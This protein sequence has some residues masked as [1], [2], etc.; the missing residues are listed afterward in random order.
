M[1]MRKMAGMAVAAVLL[2]AGAAQADITIET[3]PV[4]NPGNAADTRTQSD[5]TSGYGAVAYEYN[6]GKYEVTAGQYTAFLNAVAATDIYSLY[7]TNMWSD[8][9]GCKIRRSG[10]SG[11]YTYS[12]AGDYA[13]RPVNFVSWGDSVRF[14][15]WLTNGQGSGSTETGA[16]NLN[17]AVT[18]PGLMSMVVPS[19]S[20]R[21]AWSTGAKPYFLLTSEDEWYKAAYHDKNAA[22][23][24]TYFVYPTG[25]NTAPT[26]T[27]VANQLSV[28]PGSA[29]YHYV[30]D[31]P[32][33]VGA[34]NSKP[35]T[36]A[37]GTF[38][39]GGNLA[40]WN[41]AVLG[42][43]RG[44]RGGA[45]GTFAYDLHAS[46]REAYYFPTGQDGSVGFRVSEV[47]EPASMAVL[48][49]GSIGMLLRR[50]R[51]MV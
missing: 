6:I 37:Y 31:S 1:Q 39:Q 16:Y 35:S 25:S 42:P 17:G 12:V 14:A 13:N 9:Y 50:R 44:L 5:G 38:D 36:S 47:P 11:S 34:Y 41:E 29:N 40:E 43:C 30:V 4:G 48:A 10:S 24:A 19:A 2:A 7:N 32:T 49:L 3:V 28:A 23:A 51:R 26:A 33:N 27:N 18:N 8:N 15:N 45:F 22:L 46:D 21:A 20:Q